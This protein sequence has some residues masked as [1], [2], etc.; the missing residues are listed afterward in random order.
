[1]GVSG[2]GKSTVG[3]LLADRL[4]WEFYDG[5][6]FLPPADIAKMTADIPLDD[7]DRA[8]WLARLHALIADCLHQNRPG[9][10]ACSALKQKYRDTLLQGN[11]GL[12]FIY[13]KGDYDT[14]LARISARHNHFMKSE[15]LKSQ[16]A[17]LEE[18]ADALVVD[19]RLSP[20]QMVE[21]ILKNNA[22]VS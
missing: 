14:I 12:R 1:M 7:S 13:L 4:G 20:E 8:P 17:A 9:V 11:P 18:P 22:G 16:F 19:V 21:F 6:D 2:C 10:L 5:D 15:M 3:K